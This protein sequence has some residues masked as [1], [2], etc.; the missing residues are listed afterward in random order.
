MPLMRQARQMLRL[1]SAKVNFAILRGGGYA[2]TFD[3][4]IPD[5]VS[6]EN[7]KQISERVHKLEI[8]QSGDN[9]YETKY[10]A[11]DKLSARHG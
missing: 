1:P 10:E 7:I 8:Y 6:F 5:S 9:D 11:M 2:F 4:S 3:H